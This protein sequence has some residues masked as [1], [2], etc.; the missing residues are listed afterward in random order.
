MAD[1]E[2]P[3]RGGVLR[4]Y[5]AGLVGNEIASILG[6]TARDYLPKSSL[7]GNLPKEVTDRN[8]NRPMRVRPGKKSI[9]VVLGWSRDITIKYRKEGPLRIK[10]KYDDSVSNDELAFVRGLFNVMWVLA[11]NSVSEDDVARLET[12]RRK[13]RFGLFQLGRLDILG[14]ADRFRNLPGFGREA[15]MLV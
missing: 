4:P 2:R 7:S 10:M 12:R 13:L 6:Q 15:D 9:G 14:A 1:N 11:G 3:R 8:F 5:E